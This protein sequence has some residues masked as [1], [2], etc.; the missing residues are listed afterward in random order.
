MSCPLLCPCAGR[1]VGHLR[2]QLLNE[3]MTFQCGPH[4][5]ALLPSFYVSPTKQTGN[6]FRVG[7]SIVPLCPQA[8]FPDLGQST[9]LRINNK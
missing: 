5:N 1:A 7:T 6:S 3:W 2:K 4:Q 9:R 8:L